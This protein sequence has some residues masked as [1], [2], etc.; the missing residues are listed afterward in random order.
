MTGGQ[1]APT[2]PAG[3]STITT[4]YGNI[5]ASFD[6]CKLAETAGAP[7]V[8]RW[9]TA[10]PHPT[11]R[12]VMKGIRKKGTAFIEILSQCP[13]HKKMSPADMLRDLKKN[14]VRISAGK[15]AE[16]GRI[17]IGE[18]CDIEKPE[19]LESYQKIIDR[20]AQKQ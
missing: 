11:I 9:T 19:W 2:T 15:K 10:H 3:I 8:A 18:F 12:S 6:L 16:D 14:T 1:V 5:E 7:F 17:P 4:P 13:V 20:F